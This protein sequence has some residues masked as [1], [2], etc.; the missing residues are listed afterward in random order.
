MRIRKSLLMVLLFLCVLVSAVTAVPRETMAKDNPYYIKI[1]KGTNVVTV[2]KS[3]GTPYKAFVCSTG[4][5]TPTGTFY[6]SQK[7]RWHVL[8]GPSY[9]QYCTRIT[10]SILFHSVW[11]YRNGD[12]ASQS[13][14][15]YNKLGTTASHGCV[16]LT[17]ADS[18][19]I[20]DNCPIRTKVIIFNGKSS[21]DPLGK[22]VPVK[23]STASRTGWDPTDPDSANPYLKMAPTITAKKTSYTYNGAKTVNIKNLVSARAA[24]GTY[25]DSKLVI[26]VKAPGSKS[27]KKVTAS[28][29]KFSEIGT[30][31]ITYKVTDPK[32][33]K[34][35]SKTVKIIIK[36]NGKPVIAGTTTKKTVEYNTA[37][38][39][40]SSVTAKTKSGTNLKSYMTVKIKNPSGKSATLNANTYT[41]KQLGTYTITY[42]VK[43]PVGS[44]KT[45]KTIKITVKDTKTPTITGLKNST[46][47]YKSSYN[48][49]TGVTAKAATGVS[50][51]SKIKVSV[52]D[53]S[54]KA[55]SVSGNKFTLSKTGNYKVKYTVTGTNGK[56][57]TQ[58]ITVK[59]VD[60][61][62]PA[63]SNVSSKTVTCKTK[64]DIRSAVKVL[65]PNGTNL[66]GYLTI[67]ITTPDK[68]IVTLNS[69]VNEYTFDKV[70]TYNIT[71]SAVNPNGKKTVTKTIVYNVIMYSPGLVSPDSFE[72]DLINGAA[73]FGVMD[74]VVCIDKNSSAN[75]ISY[76]STSVLYQ[77]EDEEE[78]EEISIVD[79]Q[80]DLDKTGVYTITYTV[81]GENVSTI[82]KTI[83]IKV[84]DS[85]PV[86]DEEEETMPDEPEYDEPEYD[87]PEY[88]EPEYD[89]PEYDEPEYQDDLYN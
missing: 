86:L 21:D 28:S 77:S 36:D 23:V 79:G 63:I 8:M 14:A 10:G 33:K 49:K 35:T 4:K 32:N 62:K 55:V 57:K 40:K 11:Y 37:L 54:G 25:L 68:T 65:T 43:N 72:Y 2:Y 38:N 42:S 70:G 47:E 45:T 19:W 83:T 6:T 69:S 12:K 5:A 46:K 81:S 30:Y 78:A 29:Y 89:E 50:L 44:Q 9:G 61:G 39:L 71:Y 53:P 60:T 85:T 34:T 56:T 3:D 7:L 15:E 51:T 13:T 74:G 18:K 1:N 31:T 17:V 16:R 82:V 73:K 87:E 22:P 41:F 75:L 27:A 67:K 59:S 80:L 64:A 58:T 52:T 26:S 84:N 20:Y 76:V 88:D 48:V 66:K 24:Y